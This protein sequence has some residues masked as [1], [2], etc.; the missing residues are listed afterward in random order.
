MK[1]QKKARQCTVILKSDLIL[2]KEGR[3][4]TSEEEVRGILADRMGFTDRLPEGKQD[5]CRYHTIGGYQSG[6]KLQKPHVP[7]V[8]AGSVYCLK[9]PGKVPSVIQIGSFPQEGFGVC[10]VMTD[11]QM[12]Q[13]VLVS[14]GRIDRVEPQKNEEY[15]RTVY[16]RLLVSA[17]LEKM[18]EY[19]LDYHVKG[20]RIPVARLR[21]MLSEA[22]EYKDFL[23]MIGTIK[24]SDVSSEN[25]SGRKKDS[26]ELVG[27]STKKRKRMPYL[28]ENTGKRQGSV[29]GNQHLSGGKGSALGN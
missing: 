29:C 15:I 16:S 5:Y 7:A 3:F 9:R 10:Y 27:E 12:R 17:G 13:A 18:R 20:D 23:R 2:Q 26:E 1:R 28:G 19:A 25:E 22:K 11:S 8:R 14:E 24:E 6:W 4:V 21:R